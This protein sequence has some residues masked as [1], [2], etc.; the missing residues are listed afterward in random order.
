MYSYPMKA[1]PKVKLKRKPFFTKANA[2]EMRERS[3]GK[4]GKTDWSEQ[5]LWEEVNALMRYVKEVDLPTL[6]FFSYNRGYS[7]RRFA[8][9]LA[10]TTVYSVT[11]R[12]ALEEAIDCCKAKFAV[13]IIKG[14]LKG[15]FNGVMVALCLRN[16]SSGIDNWKD[17]SIDGGM[18]MAL[19][20]ITINANSSANN[21]NV[22]DVEST[23][24]VTDAKRE[25]LA[26]NLGIL[27]R[28][29]LLPEESS[30]AK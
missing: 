10:N 20:P 19:P 26:R 5:E 23:V 11:L 24:N 4:L 13:T 17:K 21:K 28:H 18:P 2:R 1:K 15:K 29:G 7:M 3:S 22:I 12:T 27:R 25:R 16:L 9:W 6:Y 14:G 8:G 30:P